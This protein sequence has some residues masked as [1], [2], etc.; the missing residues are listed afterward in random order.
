MIASTPTYATVPTENSSFY[1]TDKSRIELVEN[2]SIRKEASHVTKYAFPCYTQF[3]EISKEYFSPDIIE[4][5]SSPFTNLDKQC[6]NYRKM[7]DIFIDRS[8]SDFSKVKSM[9]LK[10]VSVA[11]LM[12]LRAFSVDYSPK[13]CTIDFRLR[14]N[15]GIRIDLSKSID[16]INDNKIAF[17]IMHQRRTIALN[18]TEI[19]TFKSKIESIIAHE[20]C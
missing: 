9:F 17:A 10:M 1:G 11:N 4:L 6:E 19:E 15:N 20:F 18:V 16:T 13:T 14:L 7:M 5:E 2:N 8:G 12:P 3:K